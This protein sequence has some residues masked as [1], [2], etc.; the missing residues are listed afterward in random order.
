MEK[1]NGTSG[2]AYPIDLKEYPKEYA[3]LADMLRFYNNRYNTSAYIYHNGLELAIWLGDS[4]KEHLKEL[5]KKFIQGEGFPNCRFVDADNRC[6]ALGT[7]IDSG[8]YKGRYGTSAGLN[9]K[10]G[11]SGYT[12]LRTK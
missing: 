9:V 2:M 5:M 11:T 7:Y 4:F 8:E 12:A 6:L 1:D 3:E 10:S